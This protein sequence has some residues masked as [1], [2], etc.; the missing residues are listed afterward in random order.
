MQ[1]PTL[2][3]F[4]MVSMIMAAPQM[5]TATPVPIDPSAAPLTSVDTVTVSVEI[6][7]N[8]FQNFRAGVF[9]RTSL[10]R[11]AWSIGIVSSN[12]IDPRLLACETFDSEG[13][14][15]VRDNSFTS[16]S[17]LVLSLAAGDGVFVGQ[18][19]CGFR[20]LTA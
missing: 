3:H 8:S 17:R 1:V 13:N 14:S 7:P 6:A 20:E 15:L 4:V 10:G 9:T 16:D 18:F 11:E 12:G 5:P 19:G 2:L